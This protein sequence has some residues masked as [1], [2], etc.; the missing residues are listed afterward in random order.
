MNFTILSAQSIITLR[1]RQ[2]VIVTSLNI[3]SLVQRCV[4][5]KISIQHDQVDPVFIFIY[6]FI[7]LFWVPLLSVLSRV[8]TRIKLN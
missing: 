3:D 8:K 2:F 5:V 7:Y 6:L 4:L 1:A